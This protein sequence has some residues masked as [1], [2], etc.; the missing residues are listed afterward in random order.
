MYGWS[1]NTENITILKDIE[2]Y[3]KPYSYA[4]VYY[5]FNGGP[6]LHDKDIPTAYS[7]V[8]HPM[9]LLYR[10][11]DPKYINQTLL[12]WPKN[13]TYGAAFEFAPEMDVVVHQQIGRWI[14]YVYNHGRT[15]FLLIPPSNKSTAYVHDVITALKFIKKE[16]KQFEHA[17][18]IFAVYNRNFTHVS[19]KQVDS[20]I[21]IFRYNF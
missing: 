9:I 5:E 19:F 1:G 15:P 11:Y 14:D 13:I 21:K 10:G 7:Y 4:F 16:S 12:A 2:K 8:K 17:V 3:G 6:T 18:I 20:A